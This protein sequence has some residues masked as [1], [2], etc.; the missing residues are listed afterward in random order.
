MAP[1]PKVRPVKDRLD[2][3]QGV[4]RLVDRGWSLVNDLLWSPRY[5]WLFTGLVLMG[6]LF[7]GLLII[8]KV[9]CRLKPRNTPAQ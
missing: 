9:P 8:Q 1:T 5:Y 7:L 6:E 2:D 4:Q 3:Q